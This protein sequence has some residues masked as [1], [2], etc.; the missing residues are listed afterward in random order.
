ML[1]TIVS[2]RNPKSD[3]VVK[4]EHVMN[5]YIQYVSI[6]SQKMHKPLRKRNKG[7]AGGSTNNL[8]N[9]KR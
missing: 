8:E 2:G 4:S 9:T 3:T 1:L 5:V 6:E 7:R